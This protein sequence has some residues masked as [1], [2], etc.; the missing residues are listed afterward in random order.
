M[1][2]N[3]HNKEMKNSREIVEIDGVKYT[4][5]YKCGELLPLDNFS[6]SSKGPIGVQNWC[7]KC[8]RDNRM[9]VARERR[10]MMAS[11]PADLPDKPLNKCTPRDLMAA[12]KAWGYSGTLSYTQTIDI[13]RI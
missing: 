12:L 7:K 9:S 8:Q 11:V 13:S 4:T 6:K 3:T 1:G 2:R 10:G 5:C